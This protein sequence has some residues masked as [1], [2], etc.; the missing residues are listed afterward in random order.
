MPE[1]EKKQ[2]KQKINTTNS[3]NYCKLIAALAFFLG[4]DEHSLAVI[5]NNNNK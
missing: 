1:I 5:E 2:N 4:T 3:H